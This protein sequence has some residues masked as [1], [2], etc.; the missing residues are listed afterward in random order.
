M[1]VKTTEVV[2]KVIWKMDRLV[3][4]MKLIGRKDLGSYS[5]LRRL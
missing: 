4:M 2:A 5:L 1:M 3:W